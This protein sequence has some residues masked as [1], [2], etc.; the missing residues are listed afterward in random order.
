MERAKQQTFILAKAIQWHMWDGQ[1]AAFRVY[2]V[3][4]LRVIHEWF[5]S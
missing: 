2:V 4:R 1:L 5:G 3:A